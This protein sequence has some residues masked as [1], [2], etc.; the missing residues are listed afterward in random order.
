MSTFLGGKADHLTSHHFGNFYNHY[1]LLHYYIYS[2][3]YPTSLPQN[4]YGQGGNIQRVSLV[5][6]PVSV[7]SFEDNVNRSGRDI[8][9]HVTNADN[10]T[11]KHVCLP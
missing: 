11:S 10:T 4:S 7:L 1:Y 8:S 2:G 3:I 9:N 6:T 5:L